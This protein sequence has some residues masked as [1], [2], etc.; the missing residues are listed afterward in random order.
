[1]RI[2]NKGEEILK[3][4]KSKRRDRILELLSDP[5]NAN[6]LTIKKIIT[7]LEPDTTI[8]DKAG[9]LDR[10]SS[11]YKSWSRTLLAMGSMGLITKISQETVW[12]KV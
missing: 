3:Y 10:K 1:M 11:E 8:Y 12:V 9:K 7:K 6:G 2:K 5:K 4:R